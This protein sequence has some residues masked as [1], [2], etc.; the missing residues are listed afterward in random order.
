LVSQPRRE[1]WFH[2]HGETASHG[3]LKASIRG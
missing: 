3:G 2:E 1:K